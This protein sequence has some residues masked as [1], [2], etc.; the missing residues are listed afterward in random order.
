MAAQRSAGQVLYPERPKLAALIDLM[1][2]ELP[3]DVR[4]QLME[5]MDGKPDTRKEDDVRIYSGRIEGVQVGVSLGR[6]SGTPHSMTIADDRLFGTTD[7][8]EQVRKMLP[9]RLWRGEI[10]GGRM[11]T[12]PAGGKLLRFTAYPGKIAGKRVLI[13]DTP[14]W[15]FYSSYYDYESGYKNPSRAIGEI[16]M[17]D[18]NY[19]RICEQMEQTFSAFGT[20]D[21]STVSGQCFRR[22]NVI[23]NKKQPFYYFG[24]VLYNG[25]HR[26]GLPQGRATWAVMKECSSYF[27]N[28][29]AHLIASGRFDAGR[30]TGWHNITLDSILFEGFFEEGQLTEVRDYPIGLLPGINGK[31]AGKVVDGQLVSQGATIT[32]GETVLTPEAFNANGQLTGSHTLVARDGAIHKVTLGQDGKPA[33]QTTVTNASGTWEHKYTLDADGNKTDQRLTIYRGWNL[34]ITGGPQ[35]PAEVVITGTFVADVVNKRF[36]GNDLT[37]ELLNERITLRGDFINP[38]SYQLIS[39]PKGTHQMVR[40]DGTTLTGNYKAGRYKDGDKIYEMPTLSRSG[41]PA[42]NLETVDRV[43]AVTAGEE[44]VIFPVDYVGGLA[45]THNQWGTYT[46]KYAY[47]DA[48]GKVLQAFEEAVTGN[49]IKSRYLAGLINPKV[50]DNVASLRVSRDYAD[51]TLS[52]VL[53]K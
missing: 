43:L 37:V 50:Y 24:N 16:M 14:A 44:E 6:K 53:Y 1:T 28:Q 13:G 7:H 22:C 31:F 11:H 21:L 5:L 51:Y 18:A 52:L 45:F 4:K 8:R 26:G 36:A 10:E 41:A 23:V 19:D 34:P 12:D 33:W 25:G 46:V 47:L 30:P 20:I 49:E 40:S 42:F 2:T 9:N 3:I 35:R 27:K 29:A 32:N 17:S 39:L 15:R 38:A 48:D